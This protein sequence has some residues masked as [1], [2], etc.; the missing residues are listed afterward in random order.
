M[1][2]FLIALNADTLRAHLN[3]QAIHKFCMH[4]CRTGIDF[5][6]T[7]HIPRG[8]ADR[9]NIVDNLHSISAKIDVLARGA[10]PGVIKIPGVKL[11]AAGLVVANQDGNNPILIPCDM[12][13]ETLMDI[14]PDYLFEFLITLVDMGITA[15][16]A[17]SHAPADAATFGNQ[18]RV[19][20]IDL[21]NQ[22]RLLFAPRLWPGSRKDPNTNIISISMTLEITH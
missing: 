21:L 13:S 5:L 9:Y 16:L 22:I 18:C 19:E 7:R 12:T 6:A 15:I 3:P 2:I 11:L 14:S 8:H 17:N 1:P 4:I 10:A 20:C